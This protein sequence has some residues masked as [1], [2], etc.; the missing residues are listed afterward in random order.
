MMRTQPIQWKATLIAAVV[1]LSIAGCGPRKIAD[2]EKIRLYYEA[3]IGYINRGQPDKAIDSLKNAYE[4]DHGYPQVLH[5]LG[6]AYLQLGVPE[7]ALIWFRKTEEL[8]PDDSQLLNNL[9]STYLALK[10]YDE[11]IRYATKALADL[12]YRTPAAAHYNRGLARMHTGDLA[13]AEADFMS[14]IRLEPLYDRPRVELA[15]LLIRKGMYDTAINHLTSAVKINKRNAEAYLLRGQANWERGLV[16]QAENDFN[17]VI[18]MD[19]ASPAIM[20]QAHNWLD[21]IQ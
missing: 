8:T 2:S 4:L 15:R 21:R 5:A 7:T 9:S 18:R 10:N 13:G 14:A 3:G 19:S 17:H 20:D 6:L 1:L 12:N 11:T 16:T